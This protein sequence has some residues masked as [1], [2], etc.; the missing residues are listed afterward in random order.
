MLKRIFMPSCH[1]PL[2]YGQSIL[3]L[4]RYLR[5]RG[6]IDEVCGCCKPGHGDYRPVPEGADMVVLCNTCA[7]I[8]EESM[9]C[10]SVTSAFE[11]IDRDPAFPFPDYGGEPVTVQDCW[12]V[13][14]NHGLH[15]SVRSLMR[16]MNLVPVE[17]EENRDRSCFCGTSLLMA[18][19]E[20]NR[21]LAPK[22]FGSAE[23][24]LFR[25]VGADERRAAMKQHASLITTDRAVTYCFS[26]DNGLQMGGIDSAALVNLL[27]DRLP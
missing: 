16:K 5:D 26:C 17:L 4:E 14:G 10:R 13:R 21:A 25:P 18:P 24:G 19:S 12:R 3:K 9:G 27:F 11:L 23:N 6:L 8:A 7:A 15:E 22:R 20:A 2:F 1:N